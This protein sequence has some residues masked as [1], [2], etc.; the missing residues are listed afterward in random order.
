MNLAEFGYIV[1]LAQDGKWED[2]DFE[3]FVWYTTKLLDYDPK[4]VDMER[5]RLLAYLQK[6]DE[7]EENEDENPKFDYKEA[8][9]VKSIEE[10]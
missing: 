8:H 10:P 1:Y 5:Y 7:K 9:K 3:S 2:R 6:K 4:E